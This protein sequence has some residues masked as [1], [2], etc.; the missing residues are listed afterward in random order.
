MTQTSNLEKEKRNKNQYKTIISWILNNLKFIIIPGSKL[1]ILTLKQNEYEK[2]VSKRKLINRFKS[3]MTIIGIIFILVILSI[4]VF[5]SWIS[6]Y[7]Y[8]EALMRGPLRFLPPSPQHP[9]GTTRYGNDVLARIIFGTRT[10][11]IIVFFSVVISIV[12]GI[13]LGLI[14]AYFGGWLDLII[15]RIMELLLSFPGVI[16][17]ITILIIWQT[18]LINLI[19]V[20]GFIGIPYYTRTMRNAVLKVKDLPYIDAAKLMGASKTR[21]LFRHILPNSIQPIIIS[22]SFNIGR[23]LINLSI[24][25]FLGLSDPRWID[26]GSDIARARNYL[27]TAPWCLLG[28]SIMILITVIGFYLL[29]DGLQDALDPKMKN[30]K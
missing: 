8:G 6:P 29:G 17:A 5:E 25:A 9:L 24:L 28:P 4:A 21:I 1:K 13:P 14:S 30:L 12:I 7:S 15:M 20:F 19:F 10:C 3:P 18:T 16:L 22:L 2:N 23:T 11:L 26:W 27:I